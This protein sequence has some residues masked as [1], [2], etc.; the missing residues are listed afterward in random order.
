M[1]WG[2]KGNRNHHRPPQG[3]PA[4][5]HLPSSV[6]KQP[7]PT[8]AKY[9]MGM[10]WEGAAGVCYNPVTNGGVRINGFIITWL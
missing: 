10:E 7:T 1:K 4:T 3:P 8:I 5:R 2:N 6:V 9:Y